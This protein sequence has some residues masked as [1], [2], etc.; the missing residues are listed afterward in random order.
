MPWCAH[1]LRPAKQRCRSWPH[2]PARCCQR[3]VV[4]FRVKLAPKCGTTI[5][6]PL[7]PFGVIALPRPQS[8][9]LRPLRRL[10]P[11][12]VFASHRTFKGS[13][14]D[15]RS[16]THSGPSPRWTWPVRAGTPASR[17]RPTVRCVPA[18]SCLSR[19]GVACSR[20]GSTAT[21]RNIIDSMAHKG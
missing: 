9:A 10:P 13:A 17:A 2:Q 5:E 4:T 16:Q 3:T 20:K 6:C 21:S 15:D 12:D 11:G 18:L 7:R 1:R 8:S 19:F 14:L